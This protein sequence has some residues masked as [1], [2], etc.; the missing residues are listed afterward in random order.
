MSHV[1]FSCKFDE[2]SNFLKTHIQL[3]S[4]FLSGFLILLSKFQV[5]CSST[6]VEKDDIK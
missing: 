2:D 6:R 3:P 5:F 1:N 4:Q